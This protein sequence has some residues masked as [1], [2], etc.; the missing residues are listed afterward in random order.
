MVEPNQENWSP[1]QNQAINQ[2]V[3]HNNQHIHATHTYTVT[4]ID[5]TSY[6]IKS[7]NRASHR[8]TR[9]G[10]RTQNRE[11]RDGRTS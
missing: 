6:K 8:K 5:R 9:T 10:K 2:A 3:S 11:A 4:E 7:G 1:Q